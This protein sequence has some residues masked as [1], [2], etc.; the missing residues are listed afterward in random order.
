MK[1][2]LV[3]PLI[4]TR[5]FIW[6]ESDYIVWLQFAR[7]WTDVTVYMIINEEAE[8]PD[9]CQLPNIVYVRVKH[10]YPYGSNQAMLSSELYELFNPICG[11]YQVDCILTSKNIV[12][13]N[14]KRLFEYSEVLRIPVIIGESW[15]P[16]PKDSNNVLEDKLKAVSYSECPTLFPTEREKKFAMRLSSKWLAG[17]SV[18]QAQANATVR[19]QGISAK[20]VQTIARSVEKFSQFTMTFAARFNSNKRWMEVLEAYENVHKMT[21]DVRIK[22]VYLSSSVDVD[23]V[24]RFKKVEFIKP[25]PYSK[26]LELLGKSH[27][28]VS[29]S[30]DENFSFGW[31]EQICTGNP[32]LFPKQN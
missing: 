28:F 10:W 4:S 17:S 32:I 15:V 29:M 3:I 18:R 24:A 26:Y 5:R 19:S 30:M 23:V 6:R 21:G 8:I 25:L 11:K 31:A 20:R 7:E 9:E 27:M 16:E 13:A 1:R 14:V 22:A 12:A 2:I